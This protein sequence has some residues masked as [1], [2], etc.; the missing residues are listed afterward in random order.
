MNL[1]KINKK[2]NTQAKCLSYLEKLRWGKNVTC[3]K[4]GSHNTV[5]IKTQAGR[6]HCNS[7]KTT[8]SVLVDTIFENTRLEL[9][10][11]FL[12]IGLMLNAKK[13]I[14]AKQ[15]MRDTGV[16]YKTAWYTAMRVRCGMINTCITLQNIVEMDEAYVGGKP[17]KK[18]PVN[19]PSLIDVSNKRGRG[20][21]KTPIVGIVERDGDIVLKVIEKLTSRNLISMLK[22]NVKTDNALLITDEYRAYKPMDKEVEHLV[23]NH[24]KEYSRGIVHTNNIE[25]FWSIVKNS[26]RGQYIALSKKYLP[27]YL[28]QAQY[29]FNLRNDKGNLFEQFLINAVNHENPMEYYKPIRKVK[30]IVYKKCK[31][32]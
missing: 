8:F 1:I 21:R 26:I 30:D 14:A 10:K 9:P 29:I 11:W 31:I 22:D 16:T 13:G 5:R 4:C 32:S 12:I 25:G 27:F 6:H 3:T 18:L 2:Y 24:K 19:K 28:V 7:C 23:I 20:T 17:R 15:L